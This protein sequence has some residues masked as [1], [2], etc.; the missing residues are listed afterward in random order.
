MAAKNKRKRWMKFRH[1][2]VTAL[3][4]PLFAIFIKIKYRAECVRFPES[5][6]RP[7]LILMNHQTGFD[8]FFIAVCFK[9]PVYYIATEDIFSLGFISK[10]ISYLV[11]PIPIKKQ[12]TDVRAALNCIHIA[13]EGGTI[14]L[15]PEGN[16]TYSGHTEYI[17]ES[18][19]DL[20]KRI[21]LP[22]AIFRIEGGYGVQPRWAENIRKGKM[23]AGVSRV[24]ESE[25]Y[26]NMSDGE[27]YSLIKQELYVN[28]A[29]VDNEYLCKRSAE[30]LERAIYVCPDC[31]LSEFESNKTKFTCKKC[32]LSA[33]YSAT[34]EFVGEKDGFPF[35]FVGDWYEYQNRFINGFDPRE[36]TKSPLYTDTVAFS[37]VILYKSKSLIQKDAQAKLFGDRIEVAGEVF[38]FADAKVITVLGK[39]KL[40]IYYG[41]KV[42]QF[43][44][45]KRFNAL[46][47]MHMFYRYKNLTEGDANGEFLGI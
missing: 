9:G 25:E 2:V 6:K 44:G 32:G 16:R 37:E 36:H 42:Y 5:G 1:K 33:E 4:K 31:G 7:F 12:T 30:Y 35:R 20:A 11:A 47:Y 14:A 8:Q 21:K 28:E 3:L 19:V 13:R 40:N 43:K 23:R 38:Y 45:G 34:K 39:N 10:V 41:D 18:I 15:A 27:L 17:K 46:K 26:L 22:I 29:K 24:I